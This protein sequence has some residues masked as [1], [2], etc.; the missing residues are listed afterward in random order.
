MSRAE[1]K[2]GNIIP[3]VTSLFRVGTFIQ[4][5]YWERNSLVMIDKYY[6][7]DITK[8]PTMAGYI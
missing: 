6:Y 2:T 5:T 3:I 8:Q 7:G 4:N 1:M